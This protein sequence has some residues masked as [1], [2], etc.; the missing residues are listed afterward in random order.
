[1]GSQYQRNV[2]IL[3]EAYFPAPRPI[4]LTSFAQGL[5]PESSSLHRVAS[6]CSLRVFDPSQ[7]R[8]ISSKLMI[9]LKTFIVRAC[10]ELLDSAFNLARRVIM[11]GFQQ[12]QLISYLKKDLN[13]VIFSLCGK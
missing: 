3:R 9:L 12:S 13:G 10:R 5:R 2:D 6:K 4:R 11:I 1:M 8:L 7:T